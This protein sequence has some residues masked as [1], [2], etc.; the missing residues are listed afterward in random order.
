[1]IFNH[2]EKL[3][4]ETVSDLLALFGALLGLLLC[5]LFRFLRGLALPLGA[6]LLLQRCLAYNHESDLR[7]LQTIAKQS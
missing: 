2:L 7:C 4:K 5:A 6:L 1:M 3:A